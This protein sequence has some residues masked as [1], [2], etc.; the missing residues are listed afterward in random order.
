MRKSCRKK[1][2]KNPGQISD[3]RCTRASDGRSQP[4]RINEKERMNEM[5]YQRSFDK[6]TFHLAEALFQAIQGDTRNHMASLDFRDVVL[7][8]TSM[9]KQSINQEKKVGIASHHTQ[10]KT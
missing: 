3:E 8:E 10:T 9:S 4:K 7:K 1:T 5:T 2:Q 6:S